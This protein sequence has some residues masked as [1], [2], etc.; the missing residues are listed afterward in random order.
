MTENQE[1]RCQECGAVLLPK[2]RVCVACSAPVT[3]AERQQGTL[4]EIMREMPSTRQ[5]DKTVVFV[6]EY[7][8]ARLKR[9]RRNKQLVIAA[10]VG[11]V[12]LMAVSLTVWRLNQRKK[13][14]VPKQ[15]RETMAKRDLDLYTKAFEDFRADLGRYPTVQEGLGALLKRPAGMATWHGPY[16]EADYSV[17]PW[18][19]DYVYQSLNDARD[20]VMFSFGPEGESAGRYYMRISSGAPEPAATPIP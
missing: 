12:I 2:R 13:A 16:I 1:R 20:Y 15:Q 18:G 10:L 6:P 4:A 5:P 14:D 3:G 19:H 7:K 11:I 17:D 9:E 8:E